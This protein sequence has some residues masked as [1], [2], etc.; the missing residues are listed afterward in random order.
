MVK[1]KDGKPMS[2]T[3]SRRNKLAVLALFAITAFWGA[4]FVL[5]EDAITLQPVPDFLATRFVLAAAILIAI[6]P[7]TVLLFTKRMWITGG[8]TGLFLAFGYVTQTIGLDYSTAAITGFLTGLYVVLTPVLAWLLF[9]QK[10]N[11]KLLFAACLALVG[12]GTIA[13]T[14]TGVGTGEIWV[15]VSALLFA[16]HIVALGKWSPGADTYALTTMQL[17]VTAFVTSAL[18]ATD[19][20]QAPPEPSVWIA[21]IITAVF[22]TA[23]GFM[24][25]TWAQ[26]HMDASRVAI[27][28]T[29]EV[30]WAASLAVLS[31]QETLGVRT[32]IGGLIMFSAMLI[33][34]W[35]SK[36]KPQPGEI[37]PVHPAGH[38]E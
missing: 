26:A 35:P 25:Q 11:G 9:R 34:E 10:L 18:A 20:Y 33:V 5:M 8:I 2:I 36:R 12:L 19:G 21:V 4:S 38:F 30:P 27:I 17:I 31:G 13:L 24:L 15:I 1:S 14:P 32:L 3:D 6:R 28:L 23:I 37:Q 7:K 22:A 16:L 29:A